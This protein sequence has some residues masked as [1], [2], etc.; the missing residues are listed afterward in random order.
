MKKVKN[1]GMKKA[2]MATGAAMGVGAAIAGAMIFKDKKNRDKAK[3]VFFT[4]KKQME[5][6]IVE[7]KKEFNK[8]INSVKKYANDTMN[9]PEVKPIKKKIIKK[10]SS[11][12]EK[13]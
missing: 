1:N 7:G 5:G 11:K 12:N 10:L 9:T 6:K 4:V 13:I 8:V 2:A 3:K